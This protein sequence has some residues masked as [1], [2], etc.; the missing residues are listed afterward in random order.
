L[1]AILLVEDERCVRAILSAM[2]A[3]GGHHR[4]IEQEN[5]REAINCLSSSGKLDLAVLDVILPHG[6]VSDVARA[7]ERA[8]PDLPILLISGL[9][10]MSLQ[11]AGHLGPKASRTAKRVFPAKAVHVSGVDYDGERPAHC[12]NS[13]GE[14]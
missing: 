8:Q 11:V 12:G 3:R 6:C 5:A 1:A 13:A 10:V 7:I 9:D 14:R 4:V 2:L